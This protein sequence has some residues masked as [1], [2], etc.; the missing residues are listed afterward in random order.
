[1][2]SERKSN[3]TNVRLVQ[4][5]VCLRRGGSVDIVIKT[6]RLFRCLAYTYTL[7]VRIKCLSIYVDV[8]SQHIGSERRNF[9]VHT[10]RTTEHVAHRQVH[11]GTQSLIAR[12][13]NVFRLNQFL[14]SSSSH[15]RS[16]QQ[17][18]EEAIELPSVRRL[19]VSSRHIV[20]TKRGGH[21]GQTLVVK[22]QPTGLRITVRVLEEQLNCLPHG[23]RSINRA[24]LGGECRPR[25]HG[26][27][28]RVNQG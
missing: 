25:H 9:T 21:I 10:L 20:A 5:A 14:F 24:I 19:R 3:T 27:N 26:K 1:M 22:A 6:N 23:T 15:Y 13:I 4:P 16:S 8:T 17:R 2:G 28:G 12:N 11:L 18:T 7:P